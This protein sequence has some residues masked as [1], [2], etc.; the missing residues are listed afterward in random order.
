VVPDGAYTYRLAATDAAD[1]TG[2]VELGGIRVDTRPG[3]ATLAA[4]APGV[5]PNGD[6]VA[7][8]LVF[9]MAASP[10]ESVKSWSLALLDAR[11]GVARA[12][13]GG[14]GRGMPA[15]IVWD[16]RTD[17][18]RVVE[19]AY[20]A[21]LAVE[22]E[23][24]NVARA[25]LEAPVVVDVTGPRVAM[26]TE[27]PLFSPD[28]D[29]V[30]DT[31]NVFVDA[32]ASTP[33][34]SWSLRVVDPD[35]EVSASFSGRG[36]PPSPFVW[37][38]RTSAGELVESATDYALTVAATDSLGNTGRASSFVSIDLLVIRDGDKLRIVISSIYFKEFTADYRDVGEDRARRNLQTLDKLATKLA[39]YSQYV[40]GIE[41]HAVRIY[42]NDESLRDKEELMT[43]FPLSTARA[44]VVKQALV[45]RGI[46]PE[47]MTTV[48]YGGT[49]PVVPHSD[50]ENRWRN[51][52]VEFVLVRK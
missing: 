29:G 51:R 45:E 47:R 31:L 20:Q 32:E 17:A 5:S 49:R 34:V 7:D 40:I 3:T 52:R 33:L 13:S 1:N 22:Y 9:R 41:G 44:E 10:R 48:G 24:G 26:R 25:A 2:V 43:L 35:S 30:D 38:G 50:I 18:G 36:A 12:F 4:S 27:P 14:P 15:Q 39:K 11:R 16:G 6:G 8:T 21:E 46:A 19:G 42:W 23:R 37:D 28:G